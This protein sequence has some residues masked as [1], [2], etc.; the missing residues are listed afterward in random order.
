MPHRRDHLSVQI[1]VA[2]VI[3]AIN[4]AHEQEEERCDALV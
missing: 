1:V 2:M 3:K 4:S